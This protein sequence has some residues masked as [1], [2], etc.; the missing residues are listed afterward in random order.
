MGAEMRYVIIGAGAIGGTLGAH[1]LRKG[2]DVLFVDSAADHVA[3][4]NERGLTIEGFNGTF[5]TPARAVAPAELRGPLHAVLLATKAHATEAAVASFADLLAPDGFV[6]S[7]QNGLNEWTISR[8]VGRDRTIG[9]FINFSSD[10]LEPGRIHFGGPGKFAIGELDGSITPRLRTLHHAA[11]ALCPVEMTDN[12]FGYLWGKLA[13]GAMLTAT[14]L[15]NDSMGDGIDRNRELMV[16][17]AAEVL[18]VA[19]AAGVRPL[20]FDGFEPDLYRS[21]DWAAIDASL[22]RMV[23][24]RRQDQKARTGIWRDIA[25]RKRKTEVHAHYA[26]VVA[27]AERHGIPVPRLRT[28][29]RLIA[30]VETGQRQQ[31]AANLAEIPA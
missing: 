16:H 11:S 20:G 1:M 10:Y 12:I 27:E 13:Y 14:A 23:A 15:T 2:H 6:V 29:M 18:A 21:G 5:T 17:L 9:C 30:E 25:V 24:I 4:I 8:I 7:V 3:A 26:P 22:D 31:S 28:L 19:D